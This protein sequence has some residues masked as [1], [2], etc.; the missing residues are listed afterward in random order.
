MKRVGRIDCDDILELG[1]VLYTRSSGA[2]GDSCPRRAGFLCSIGSGDG[3]YVKEFGWID[4][5][6]G[7]G[8]DVLG[9]VGT[10]GVVGSDGTLGR[11]G[12]V[13]ECINWGDRSNRLRV[14]GAGGADDVPG[15]HVSY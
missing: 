7:G 2:S 12:V 3:V 1:V 14:T 15:K 4:A 10:L 9:S 13:A 5:D 8:L 6:M 11:L